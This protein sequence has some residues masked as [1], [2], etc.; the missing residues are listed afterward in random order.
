M[1]TTGATMRSGHRESAETRYRRLARMARLLDAGVAIP[2]TGIRFGADA[3]LNV[4]PGLGT[5]VA[6]ALSAYLILE[7]R[8]LGVPGSVQAKMVGHVVL[9][10]AISLVPVAG[11]IGDIFYRANL[12]NLQLLR[13]HLDREAGL[14][15]VDAAPSV[16]SG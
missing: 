9:D 3:V 16:R 4:V 1:Q 2:F 15:D 12:K 5:V 11:W 8:R 6:Q 13:E 14:I 10:T 7:A